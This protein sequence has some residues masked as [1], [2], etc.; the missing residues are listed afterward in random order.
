MALNPRPVIVTPLALAAKPVVLAVTEGMTEPTITA[1][2]LETPFVTT[3]AER[4]PIEVGR[5]VRVMVKDDA[6]AA[7]IDPTAPLLNVTELFAIVVSYPLPMIV[8][9]EALADRMLPVFA[10]TTGVTVAT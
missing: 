8:K 5:V 9:V 2:P 6:V 3:I 7:V 10:S 4:S 1:A